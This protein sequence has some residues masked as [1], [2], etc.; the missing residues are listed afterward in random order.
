MC[1]VNGKMGISGVI[2]SYLTWHWARELFFFCLSQPHQNKKKLLN[3][4]RTNTLNGT[5]N[6]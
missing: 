6:F 4:A 1:R 5:N 3:Y 2:C